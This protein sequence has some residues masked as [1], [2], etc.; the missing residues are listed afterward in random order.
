MRCESCQKFASLETGDPEV[1]TLEVSDL[2]NG[3]VQVN[4]E[5]RIVRNCADCGTEMK[6]TTLDGQEEV[7]LG[8]VPKGATAEYEIEE[9]SC[10]STESGGGRYQKNMIGFHLDYKITATWKQGKKE[11]KR[12]INGSLEDSAPA[13]AF[14]EM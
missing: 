4:Y 3:N 9:V 8:D 14:D 5:I 10:E 12:E 1:N 13:S 7:E 6:E 11:G 2:G